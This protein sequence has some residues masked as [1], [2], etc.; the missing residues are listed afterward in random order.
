MSFTCNGILC[1]RLDH[2]L[3]HIEMKSSAM[4]TVSTMRSVFP[5][6]LCGR[7]PTSVPNGAAMA[8]VVILKEEVQTQDAYENYI[9]SNDFMIRK[10]IRPASRGLK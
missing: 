7:A 1:N 10:G 9:R 6:A 2:N 8:Y 4:K 3:S 5:G